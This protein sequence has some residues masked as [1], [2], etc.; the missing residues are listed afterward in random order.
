MSTLIVP[1]HQ[2]KSSLSQLVKRAVNGETIFIG[3]YGRP[4][5]ILISAANS[6]PKKR[7]GLLDGKLTIPDDFDDP[8]PPEILAAFEGSLE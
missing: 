5:V 3:S 4:E 1:I 7:L 2:A 6:R 8:L